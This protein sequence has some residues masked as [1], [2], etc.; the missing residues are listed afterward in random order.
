MRLPFHR[1]DKEKRRAEKK[2]AEGEK[3]KEAATP[4]QNLPEETVINDAPPTLTPISNDVNIVE[5]ESK[6]PTQKV[7]T[8]E[9]NGS[10]FTTSEIVWNRAYDELADENSALVEG[11]VRILPR[12]T[13]PN[14]DI[15]GPESDKLVARMKDPRQRQQVMKDALN[16]GQKKVEKSAKV[17]SVVGK[18]SGFVLKFKGVIDLA[19][20][21]NP[22]AAL[23]WAGACIGLQF[24]LNPA[25]ASQS[26]LE[27]I[28]YVVT[29]MQ[30]YCALTG[31]MLNRKNIETDG[32]SYEE[33]LVQLENRVVALYK[34]LLTY[35]MKSVCHYYKN[36]GLVWLRN[37]INL[38]DWDGQ[39]AGV[40]SSEEA[41]Q[42]DSD[43]YLKLHSKDTLSAIAK[44]GQE[45]QNILGDLNL[46]MHEYVAD[47]KEER[48]ERKQKAREADDKS[49]LLRLLAFDK[50]ADMWNDREGI[51]R[52]TWETAHQ[53]ILRQRVTGTGEWL[54]SDA[55]FR[56][57][58]N[59]AQGAT[60]LAIVGGESS[61]KSYLASSV[62]HHL[63][64]NEEYRDT[65]LRRVVGFHFMDKRVNNT[66]IDILAKSLVWQC[67]NGDGSYMQ[68]AANESRDLGTIDPKQMLPQLLFE[69]RDLEGIKAAFYIVIN[70]LGDEGDV[71]DPEMLNLL[72]S[73][74]R[75]KNRTAR[76][77]FT[78]TPRTIEQV[79]GRGIACPQIAIRDKNEGDILKFIDSRMDSI[80]V[81]SDPRQNGVPELREKVKKALSDKTDGDYFKITTALNEIRLSE[82][83]DEIDTILN[84]A[85]KGTDDHIRGEINKLN[86]ARTSK[87]IAEI[88]EI[89]LWVANSQERLSVEKM[90]VILQLRSNAA[91]LRSLDYKFKTSY[92]LFGIDNDGFVELRSSKFLELIPQRRQIAQDNQQNDQD[93]HPKEI[94]VVQYFLNTVCPPELL[95]K[96]QMEQ[97]LQRMMTSKNC[98]IYQEDKNTAHARIAADILRVLA[99]EENARLKVLQGYAA[100]Q[101]MQHLSKVDLALVDRDLKS[102][103]GPGLVKLFTNNTCIDNL[104]RFVSPSPGV[105]DWM[106]EDST[107]DQIKTWLKDSAVA[108]EI[109]PKGKSWI[110]QLTEEPFL[111]LLRQSA[112][113]MAF[114]CLREP[115]PP[116]IAVPT[117]KFIL[118]FL[119]KTTLAKTNLDSPTPAEIRQAEMWSEKVAGVIER[120][121]LWEVQ[122]ALVFQG[123]QWLSHAEARCRKAL[124][125]ESSN[126]RAL[127]VLAQTVENNKEAIEILNN[128][129]DRLEKDT[130]WMKVHQKSLAKMA[131][132]LGDRHW[133]AEQFDNAPKEYSKS[134]K[135]DPSDAGTLLEILRKYQKRDQWDDAINLIKE[136]HSSRRDSSC[137]CDRSIGNAI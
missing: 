70:K 23:P 127:Q 45:S 121:A 126:W 30:W 51:P 65:D 129:I 11:Y 91:S 50:S 128:L 81:L 98:Q 130:A 12:T 71:V 136:L 26:Q 67:A 123:F 66:G 78:C 82:Y 34:A 36:Q 108:S 118:H 134:I 133:Q 122:M 58:E 137:G 16:A 113:R 60:M 5:N 109:D 18:V 85:G 112:V 33:L 92:F 17:T 44:N 114:H 2:A 74:W 14:A 117:F 68:L 27:G 29:R 39:L 8:E 79:V 73:A 49:A 32:T 62:I 3:G 110:D 106:W 125:I 56:A 52:A 21:T 20:Q 99:M 101:L 97:Y 89:L 69:N 95:R 55:S 80:D 107:A 43:T 86:E 76:I 19:V 41:V 100:R 61:G 4:Q 119:A 46:T 120:E 131:C 124:E 84:N 83:V 53:N 9:E 135:N 96:L 1:R 35:Q 6:V 22:Q 28:A 64:R 15:T 48:E 104:F 87:E 132:D 42:T 88:N 105:P 90:T 115:S 47:Q 75:S 38:D 116:N 63:R 102:Q 57:W 40:K 103:I 13:N 10:V 72:E 93:I 25:Q 77:I 24:L 37:T 94:E 59:P 111:A 7:P 54:F 31:N